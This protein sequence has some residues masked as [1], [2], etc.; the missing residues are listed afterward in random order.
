MADHLEHLLHRLAAA[1]NAQVIILRLEQRLTRYNLFH[2]ASRLE[3][4]GDDLLDLVHV[5][6]L[7]QIV[8]CT[9]FH[10]LDRGLRR[11]KCGHHDHRQLSVILP[12]APQRLKPGNTSHT[13]VH[14]HEIRLKAFNNLK[15]LFA[16]GG[17]FEVEIG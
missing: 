3:C 15:P 2:V 9:E 14:Q 12:D 11:A 16:A 6:R 4:V 8:I 10:R 1:D 13:N 17:G 7:Q 5:K